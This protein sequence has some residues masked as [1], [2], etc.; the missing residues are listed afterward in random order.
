LC[1]QPV[2]AVPD[3][4]F[5]FRTRFGLVLQGRGLRGCIVFLFSLFS[6]SEVRLFSRLLFARVFKEGYSCGCSS[7]GT[8]VACDHVFCFRKARYHCATRSDT[9]LKTPSPEPQY[10]HLKKTKTTP[11]R[12]FP[13]TDPAPRQRALPATYEWRRWQ[14]RRRRLRCVGN[15]RASTTRAL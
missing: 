10:P 11:C 15:E 8:R 7:I 1:A 13:H 14:C 6:S 9:P 3:N 12:P 2:R 5:V 4:A